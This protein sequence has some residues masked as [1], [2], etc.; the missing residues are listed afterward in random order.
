MT[1][2]PLDKYINSI[3]S[4][5]ATT[6]S[7][8]DESNILIL[9][10]RIT[11]KQLLSYE[12]LIDE[13]IV[14]IYLYDIP[15]DKKEFN[16]ETVRRCIIDIELRPYKWKNIYILRYFDTATIQAQNA[17]LKILEDC[18]QYAVIILE[19]ENP[20][21]ILDTIKSRIINLTQTSIKDPMSNTGKDIIEFYKNQNHIGLAQSLYGFKCTSQEAILILQWVYPY[22]EKEDMIR[23]SNA[24]EWLS[25]THENPWSILDGF[26]I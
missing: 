16:I 22:L 6:P 20:N 2:K 8:I 14:N 24:I 18:P 1:I 13:N 15:E 25:S 3:L 23:C 5:N 9:L 12:E 10:S 26:F 17:L 11:G 4:D 21:S 7:M 19:I